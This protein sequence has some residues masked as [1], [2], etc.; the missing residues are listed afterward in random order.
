MAMVS[1]LHDREDVA[2]YSRLQEVV[3]DAL[4]FMVDPEAERQRPEVGYKL[5][6][7]P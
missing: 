2:E 1:G 6:G 7:P 5:K 3:V 4:H